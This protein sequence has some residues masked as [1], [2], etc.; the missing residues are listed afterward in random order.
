MKKQ[1]CI[2]ISSIICISAA[3]PAV[4]YADEA[5]WKFTSTF[6]QNWY[7]RD[8]TEERWEQEFT[9]AKSAGFD[10]LILQSTYDI[11]R[12]DCTG[13]KQ[14]YSAYPSAESFCMYQ[15]GIP[16]TYHSSQNNG[17][18]LELA[19]KAAKAAD[20]QLWIGTVNDDMWWNYGWGAPS[21]YFEEWS[22]SN[23]KLG[24]GLIDEI[25]SRYGTDYGDQIA[26]W[27]YTNEIWNIDAACD[28]SDSGEYA[29]I[30]GENINSAVTAINR[31]CPEKP[32]IIS[33]FY[34]TDISVPEQFGSF[35]SG[36]ISSSRLRTIDI[37]AP[38]D[39]GGREYS[40][41]IIRKWAEAQKKAVSGH[42]HFWI[43][44]ECFDKEY[45]AKPVEQL[46]KKYN[47]TADLAEDNI[48][49]SW[50]HYYASDSTL[51]SQFKAFAAE[52]VNGDV[53][54]DGE[55][56]IAD[57]VLFQKWLLAVPDAQL[58]N[59]R[60][61]DLCTDGRLDAFDM[62][63][64]RRTLTYSH[65]TGNVTVVSTVDELCTAVKKANA[66][67]VIKVAPGEYLCG[68]Q[69]I[70][71]QADGTSEKPIILEALD[72]NDPPVL[73]GASTAN[74]YILHITGDN[75]VVDGLKL[76][77]SQKG[78]VLDNSNHTVIQNCE[79]CDT[80]AEA[81]AIRD[82]SS[83]CTVKSCNIHDT[84]LVS[85][86]YGEGV[87]IGSSKEKTEFDFN[88]N[89]NK[90]IGCTFKNVAAEHVDVKEYTT[91]TEIS[92]CTFYGDGMTGENYA[93]S[94]LDLKGN[95]CYVHDNVGYRNGNPK[96]VAAFEVHEQ[97]EGW[98]YHHVF[99]NNTLYMDQPYGSENTSRRMYVVDGWFSDFSV[100]NNRVDYGNGLVSADSQEFYNSDNVTYL[101]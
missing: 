38:Q 100:K 81:I 44:N 17:D 101:E 71:S 40:T 36:L 87:Y 1:L 35:I 79:I 15:S 73:K 8:W 20:M 55:L 76:A 5:P 57:I 28:G 82:G 92:G 91:G 26:G 69:K 97:V 62:I 67:D 60:A 37:Y 61:A 4:S 74:G 77:N 10:S 78:I 63:L 94:F 33:P 47:A 70:Y 31:N 95:D 98:G 64:M 42:M 58:R 93:G 23:S 65:N 68:S 29:R 56:N 99:E 49:F 16:A 46:R 39:G 90:V 18:A 89:Y 24:S 84:G 51:N 9:A 19:L 48:L 85:P 27:Y 88:C 66:G 86:G 83:Y 3:I 75:W 96:I 7:C 80:G 2:I 32:L 45:T 52:T 41:E 25:W 22:Y 34:N 53:N 11:V 6:I 72:K 59:W 43:N 14:D 13:D 54:G 12:G 21:S 50:N 30:I